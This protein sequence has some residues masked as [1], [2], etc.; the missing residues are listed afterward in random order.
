MSKVLGIIAEYNPFHNGHLYHLNKSKELA[1]A[2]YSIAVIGG[3]FTQRGEPSIIDKWSKAKMALSNGFDLVLELPVLYSTSSAENFAFGAIRLLDSLGIVDNIYFGAETLNINILDD[4]AEVLYKEPRD[5]KAL[6]STELNKGLSYPKAR[7]NALMMYMNNIRK[8]SN[9]LSSPNNILGIEYLKALKKCKS[10]IKAN[11]INRAASL[12]NQIEV[13][14]GIASASSIRNSIFNGFI[15]DTKAL[16]PNSS[17]SILNKALKQESLLL[18][19]LSTY[20]KEIIYT[21]RKMSVEE[22]GMLQDVSEGLENSIKKAVNSCNSI[23]EL[24]DKVCSKRYTQT[25]IQRILLYSLLN[26][27]KKDIQL[28]KRVIPYSRILG[29]NEKGKYLISEAVRV[30]PKV[31]F[32]ASVRKFVDTCTNKN[33]LAMLQKDILA[34]NIYTLGYKHNSKGNLDFTKKIISVK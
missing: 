34:T 8:Y 9:V 19:G 26:I 12:H 33:L 1:G 27:T 6:L 20:E 13:S 11:S 17:Y 18:N 23:T 28:S 21:L 2:D 25:R 24:I 22:I 14:E 32:V 3:N 29:F 4:F 16:M 31:E 7:E 10:S 5:Y 15:D 30:N